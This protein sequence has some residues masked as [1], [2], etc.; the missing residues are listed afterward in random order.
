M[1]IHVLSY[2][3]KGAV[4]NLNV[5]TLALATSCLTI[6]A[7]ICMYVKIAA[8]SQATWVIF[9]PL[10][11]VTV[12]L[13]PWHIMHS[14]LV[15]EDDVCDYLLKNLKGPTEDSPKLQIL[16]EAVKLYLPGQPVIHRCDCNFVSESTVHDTSYRS[17]II[18]ALV[19][20]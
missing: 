20:F 14:L 17:S 16:F 3:K 15:L 11:L 13:T 10:L 7:G 6:Q 5:V 9:F 4:C 19:S 1:K 8:T 12:S 2:K 18:T